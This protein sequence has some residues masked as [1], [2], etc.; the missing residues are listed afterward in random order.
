MRLAQVS[1]ERIHSAFERYERAFS[2]VTRRAGERFELRDW[3]AASADVEARLALYGEVIS[4]LLVELG[5]L[6]GAD[7]AHEE[8]WR[9]IKRAYGERATSRAN[10]ELARTFFNSTTRRIFSTVGV[11]PEIEYSAAE[12][13]TDPGETHE[14]PYRRYAGPGGLLDHARCLLANARPGAWRDAEEDATAVASRIEAALVDRFGDASFDAIECL[15]PI[16]YR[17]KGAYLIA[18]V[19][20]GRWILPL[21]LPLLHDQDGVYVDAVLTEANDVSIV[22][23]FT[24][25]YFLVD[26]ACPRETIAFL[27]T[28]LPRKAVAE[29]YTSIGF[30]KHGKTE[31]YASLLRHLAKRDD[32]FVV[33]PGAAGMVMLVF[34]L[35]GFDM[36]FKVIRDRFAPPKTTTRRDV[37]ERYR[38]VFG[39]DRVGRLIDAQEFEHLEFDRRHFSDELLERLLEEAGRTVE[40]RG[41]DVVLHHLYAERQVTPLDLYLRTA[42]ED[43]RRRAVVDYGNAIKELAAAKI[44]P[45]DFLLKNFGVTR[46]GRVVFYDYDELCALDDCRF[47][48]LPPPRTPEEE[49]DPEPW[50]SA[51]ENDIFPEEFRRFLGLTGDL[52]RTFEE[53]HAD[54][55]T[56]EFW[57]QLQD[58]HA[59]GELIDVFPYPASRRL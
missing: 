26:T 18:R 28:I 24:R 59:R 15:V 34:T 36:V 14:E 2:E 35:P 23:S 57:R 42:D 1:A 41:R 55:F 40:L 58:R 30:N 56:V 44:F 32:A 7:L 25:S 22:F 8:L 46:H 21:V 52:R 6:L 43:E 19:R 20:R 5:E 17:G 51:T 54:L 11:N 49:L 47:R 48:V 27:R 13:T 33:A 50:F 4:D 31:L 37:M 38:L 16:F 12:A 29:L 39:H 3:R 10:P 45:G 9:A 53:Q